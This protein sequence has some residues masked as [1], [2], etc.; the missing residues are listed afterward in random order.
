MRSMLAVMREVN[1]S[2]AKDAARLIPDP[3][4]ILLHSFRMEKRYVR[5]LLVRC[6]IFGSRSHRTKILSVAYRSSYTSSIHPQQSNQS[7][8]RSNH[9][10]TMLRGSGR[11]HPKPAPLTQGP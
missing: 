6:T 1:C 4:S 5:W 11:T 3:P 2:K 10:A 7:P 8:C 9:A